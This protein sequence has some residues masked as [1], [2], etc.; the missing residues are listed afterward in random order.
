MDKGTRRWEDLGS[1]LAL[2]L[3]GV[4]IV[5]KASQWEYLGAEGPG[6]GFFPFWYGV[7]ILALAVLLVASHLRRV[8][9]RRNPVDWRRVARALSTW[10]ALA[11]SVALFKILGFVVGFAILTYFVVAVMYRRPLKTAALVAVASGAGF[12]L[13]FQLALG[14]PLP[15]GVLCF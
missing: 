4:Y 3:L 15:A 2:A 13:V 6:P 9:A 14:V 11:V 5:A 10:V 8:P 7:A 1:G 12:Y